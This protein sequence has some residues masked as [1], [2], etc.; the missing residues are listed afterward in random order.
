MPSVSNYLNLLYVNLGFIIQIAVMMFFRNAIDIKENWPKYRCNPPYWIYSE[1][2]T[3]DFTYCVQN[4]QLN[5]MG[6]LLQ[7]LNYMVDSLVTI[8][9]SFNV[10]INGARQM[11]SNIRNFITDIIQNIFGVFLNIIIKFQEIIISMKDLV[12]KILGI[13]V[14]ILYVLDGSIKTMNSA[15]AGPTGQMVRKIGKIGS[16][17]H[18]DTEIELKDGTKCLMKNV[19][20]GDILIDNSSVFS[21][22][23]INN[24][25]KENF[26][27][28]IDDETNQIIYVTGNHYIFDKDDD[29]W[30]FV[31]NY[32]K[33]IEETKIYSEWF[34]CLIT[35]SG[36]IPIG[37]YTFWDWEDDCF[38]N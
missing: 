12:G 26:Y 7:P 34:S 35:S 16:C 33:S 27:K 1:N 10:N 21:V 15:W 30:K 36:Q 32:K 2:I 8:G 29:E 19:K 23:K 20:L 37:Q 22:M 4:T 9:T 31:K 11:M 6:Y 14:T 13:V 3:E 17:F 28:I 24:I 25:K 5:M 38:N 18:P